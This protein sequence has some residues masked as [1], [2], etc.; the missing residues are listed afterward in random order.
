MITSYE[1]L[2]SPA[3]DPETSAA[4]PAAYATKVW[5]GAAE[6]GKSRGREPT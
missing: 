1:N 6:G 5:C 4:V 2:I 3:K